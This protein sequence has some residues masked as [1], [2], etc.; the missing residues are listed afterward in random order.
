M[1]K[2]DLFIK[3]MKKIHVRSFKPSRTVIRINVLFKGN[4]AHKFM[5][6][7]FVFAI[8]I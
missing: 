2:K 5:D 4:L 3:S 1:K 7:F 8:A 6:L